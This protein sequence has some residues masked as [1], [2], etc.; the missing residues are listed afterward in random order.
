M[1]S[2]RFLGWRV[3]F[4]ATVGLACGLATIGA[5]TFSVFVGPLRAEM[6]WSQ[7]EAFAA[8]LAVTFTAALLSPVIKPW[9]EIGQHAMLPQLTHDELV[10]FD[11][12]AQLNGFAAQR[13]APR[14]RMAY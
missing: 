4:A 13:L 8:L 10:R 6:G 2:N 12:V 3:V 7:S 5:A 1:T 14:V 11:M 9:H